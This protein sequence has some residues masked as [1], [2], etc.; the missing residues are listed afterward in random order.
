MKRDMC[1]TMSAILMNIHENGM[2]DTRISAGNCVGERLSCDENLQH[3]FRKVI[4]NSDD[5]MPLQ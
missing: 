2:E 5:K 4:H 3:F 1:Y